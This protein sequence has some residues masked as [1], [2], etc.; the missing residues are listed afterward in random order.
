MHEM[1]TKNN[2]LL[3]LTIMHLHTK[4]DTHRSIPCWVI[5]NRRQ[6]SHTHRH[7]HTTFRLH[8]SPLN[9]NL[10]NTLF[11]VL[12]TPIVLS[13]TH[14]RHSQ[15]D[16]I[17][18]LPPAR[19]ENVNCHNIRNGYGEQREK[20]MELHRIAGV[21]LGPCGFEAIEKFE[22][23][24]PEY[25]LIIVTRGS[26]DPIMHKVLLRPAYHCSYTTTTIISIRLRVWVDF[27]TVMD[28]VQSVWE[29]I[30]VITNT[31]A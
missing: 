13:H 11:F 21:P 12:S 1:I 27:W 29:D 4:Y 31:P 23:V 17:G 5:V 30:H 16:C 19:N 2:R 20:A 24:L 26:K 15:G 18:L 9:P 22:K 7:T 25:R 6:A 28:F 3:L 8:I 10:N 14:T